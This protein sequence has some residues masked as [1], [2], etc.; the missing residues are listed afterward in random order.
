MVISCSQLKFHTVLFWYQCCFPRLWCWSEL[1][2]SY[3]IPM[4][5]SVLHLLGSHNKVHKWSRKIFFFNR[6]WKEKVSVQL[7]KITKEGLK[8]TRELDWTRRT[9]W[10]VGLIIFDLDCSSLSV[11]ETNNII[12]LMWKRFKKKKKQASKHSIIPTST[13]G[14]FFL[15]LLCLVSFQAYW[16]EEPVPV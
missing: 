6:K 15:L 13:R 11:K 3:F 5:Q 4:S 9:S 2:T 12:T 14:D 16:E 8:W 7:W 10:E 1:T